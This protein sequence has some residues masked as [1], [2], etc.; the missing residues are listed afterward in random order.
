MAAAGQQE[1]ANDDSDDEIGLTVQDASSKWSLQ[2]FATTQDAD[3]YF[4]GKLIHKNGV[5][6]NKI[7]KAA[8]TGKDILFKYDL[9]GWWHG[10]VEG[11]ASS[12]GAE[13]YFV[14][15]TSSESQ[16]RKGEQQAVTW[17]H[18]RKNTYGTQWILA[19]RV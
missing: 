9:E 12:H 6:L 1:D 4:E 19:C 10:V 17:N 7:L 16:T 14:Q 11:V 18:L 15:F 13:T 3:D 5:H 8:M 2:I